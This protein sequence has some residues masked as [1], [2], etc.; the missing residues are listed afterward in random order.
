[1]NAYN[2]GVLALQLEGVFKEKAKANQ[3]RTTENRVCLIS[4]KQETID[5][6][7][8]VAKIANLGHDTIAKVKAIE[9]KATPEVKAQNRQSRSH[10]PYQKRGYFTT[11]QVRNCMNVR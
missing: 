7:K 5:T 11:K 10:P 8:E 2:R 9:A 6:K 3:V 1:L 4:D